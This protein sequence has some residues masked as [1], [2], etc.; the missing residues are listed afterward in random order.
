MHHRHKA[1]ARPGPRLRSD[2]SARQGSRHAAGR[3]AGST[4]S[5]AS[6]RTRG[7]Q[8]AMLRSAAARSPATM[9]SSSL[10]PRASGSSSATAPRAARSSPGARSRRPVSRRQARRPLYDARR[11]R[12]AVSALDASSHGP[13]APPRA[14]R[15]DHARHGRHH[16]VGYLRQLRPRS[17]ATSTTP[18]LIVGVWVIGGARRA[19]RRLRLRRACGAPARGRRP[20]CLS[21]RRLGA[22]AGLPLRL[23]APAGDPV[24]RNGRS[25]DHLRPLFRRPDALAASRQRRRRR[26]PCSYLR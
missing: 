22:D 8:I 20:I 2:A 16:R 18:L 3:G 24:G 26:R 11:A 21:P 10:R 9:S 23:G 4:G 13:G 5:G 7:G 1:D 19:C 14:V 6:A 17:R 12:R 25:G 15:C